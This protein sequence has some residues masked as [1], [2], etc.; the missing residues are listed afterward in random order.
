MRSVL[1]TT[2][3]LSA[4]LPAQTGCSS[5]ESNSNANAN[6]TAEVPERVS[7]VAAAPVINDAYS[8][9]AEGNRLLENGDADRAIE[10]FL[11]AARMDPD[12]AEAYFNLGIA[13]AL[14]EKRDAAVV[15][16]E[17]TPSPDPKSKK[18]RENK[19]SSE[20]A[21]EKAVA[22]YKK[23]IRVNADDD[24]AHFNLG[25]SYNK[26][27]EDEDAA[28]SLKQAVKLKPDDTEYQTELG[29]ILVKLAQYHEAI[30][31]LKQALE[32]DP[33]NI[34]AQELLDDAEAGRKRVD[35]ASPKKD[36]KRADPTA[37]SGARTNNSKP[38]PG[39]NTD[40]NPGTS[41]P[42]KPAFPVNTVN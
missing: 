11:E 27:N 3:F 26:L 42:P 6:V 28:K 21:F 12:L 22:A 39:A 36:E 32:L 34:K 31:P 30:A 17:A 9:L 2:L 24:S 37:R 41:K 23:I 40:I 14:V 38:D 18:P 4:L 10:L 19:T 25:R 1:L 35:F 29:A 13:Y 8:A 7:T 33:D 20:K 5:A 16:T 15:Q